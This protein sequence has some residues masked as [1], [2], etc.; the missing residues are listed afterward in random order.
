MIISLEIPDDRQKLADL[1]KSDIDAWCADKY[2]ETTPRKHLGSSIMGKPCDRQIWYSFRWVRLEVHEGRVQRIFQ[3]G[4]NAEP[5]FI[6]YLKG[7]GFKV[8]ERGDDG[9][10]FRITG[11]DGHY[12]GSLDGMCIAPKRYGIS[13]PMLLEFKT[14]GTG[15]GY[16]K[17]AASEL[18]ESKPEHWKQMNQYG[19]KMGLKYGLYLIE[20][21]N[22]SDITIKIVELDW[23]IGRECE[24]RA[25]DIINA[26]VPP[27]RISDNPATFE[28][29]F[30]SAKGI[31]HYNE[32]VEINCRSCRNSSAVADGKWNCDLYGEIPDDFVKLG[33]PQHVSVNGG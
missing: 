27:P 11:C 14:N 4:H 12:G 25:Q 5:R 15:A 31:C 6:T 19:Y 28:C 20:N 32:K 1:I 7:I 8:R 23:N 3:V 26:R 17:V 9:K 10:Q 24:K 2:N 22:D 29:K 33:C 16:A 21:K 30:C 18:S 13:E